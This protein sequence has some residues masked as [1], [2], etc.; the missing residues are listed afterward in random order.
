[1]ATDNTT[2][3]SPQQLR[4]RSGFCCGCLVATVVLSILFVLVL[5]M[6]FSSPGEIVAR[7]S[8]SL[9]PQDTIEQATTQLTETQMRAVRGVRPTV[10]IRV[11]DADINAYLS[12]HRDELELPSALEDPKIAF[13]EGFIEGSVRTKIGFV[14]VRVR[15]KMVPEVVDGQLVLHIKK[16]KA[17]KLGV[18][19][20]VGDRLVSKISELVGQRLEQSG[21]ELKDVQV[22]PGI[23]TITGT[24]KSDRD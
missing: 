23:L 3:Q 9:G 6:L 7:A 22:T 13:G 17:G 18:T 5:L 12:E 16:V 20:L 24:L 1:M 15:V 10:Q 21:V 8:R 11:S 2:G 4:K 19:G 14:P